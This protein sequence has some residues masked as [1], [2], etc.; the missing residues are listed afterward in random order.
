MISKIGK[1]PQT[2]FIT[3]LQ[4][5]LPITFDSVLKP[6]YP[7]ELNLLNNALVIIKKDNTAKIYHQF[8]LALSVNSKGSVIKGQAVTEEDI[9]DI[10]KLEFKDATYEVNIE[11]SD[12]IIFLFRIK[13]TFGLYFNFSK[14]IDLKNLSEL[15]GYWYKRLF[16][17]NLYSF[18]ENKDYFDKLV[19][20]GWFPFIRLIGSNFNKII[21]YYEEG[22]KHDF[23][24]DN[25]IS[26]FNKDK[27]QSFTQYWWGKDIF[28]DK[29]PILEAGISSFLQNNKEGFITCLHT[30]YP[31]IEGIMGSDYFKVYDKKPSFTELAGYIKQKAESKY[32]TLSSTGFPSEFY[33]YL[34]KTVF[35]SFDLAT[36]KI[37]LSRH[38]TSHGYANA[39]DFNKAKALQAILILDQIYFYL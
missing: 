26:E 35:E 19:K 8:P 21:T 4:N 3:S 30:L 38:T 29:K 34:N 25:L 23:H 13:W 17:S 32:R 6:F 10:V 11:S 18:I 14:N 22:K 9:F 31:Q 12:K 36:G 24:I 2:G 39:N 27:I 15:L 33:K 28:N 5:D 37:D 16:Y 7:N 20:D 1:V